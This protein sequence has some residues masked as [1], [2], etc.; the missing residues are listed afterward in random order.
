MLFKRKQI[1]WVDGFIG[2]KKVKA[3]TGFKDKSKALK[4]YFDLMEK[5]MIRKRLGVKSY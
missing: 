2:D 4:F 3:N 5:D 1:Y